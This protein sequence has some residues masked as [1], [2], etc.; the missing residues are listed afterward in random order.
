MNKFLQ[1]FTSPIRIIK[2][3]WKYEPFY[4]LLS[5]INMLFIAVLPLISVYFPKIIL[6][7]ITDGYKYSEIIITVLVYC[8]I[9]L[10]INLISNIISNKCNF[11]SEQFSRKIK[12]KI[13]VLS[14]Q[15]DLNEIESS[16]FKELVLLANNAASLTGTIGLVQ[17]IISNVITISGLM[18]IIVKLEWIF[19]LLIGITLTIKTVFVYLHFSYTKKMRFK[20]VSI[21]R[22]I[23][24]LTDITYYNNGTAKEIRLNNIQ[25]WIFEKVKI[26]RGKMVDLNIKDFRR[27]TIFDITNTVI[28]SIQTLIILWMLSARYINNDISIADF[29]MYFSAVSLLTSSLSGITEQ[30][31][32]YNQQIVN[33]N[34]FF[35][36][37]DL[38]S[39]NKVEKTVY[40]ESVN[41]KEVII[42]FEDVSFTYPGTKKEVL[43]NI[44]IE[45]E[46]NQKLVIVGYNGAGKTTFIKLLCKFYKPTKGKISINGTDI[47]D[48]PNDKYFK[49]IA[50]VFQDFANLSFSLSENI[51]MSEN[52]DEEKMMEILREIGLID[53]IDE[54]PYGIDT[55]ITRNFDSNGIELSG[56]QDQKLAIS[57]ALYKN[58]PILILDEPT[59]NLDAKSESDIYMKFFQISKHKTTIFISHRL[60][61]STVAD[62]IAVFA[63][64]SI[65]EYGSHDDLMQKN[66]IYAQMYKKQSEK[67]IDNV[68]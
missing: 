31:G 56:G 9:I 55:Y 54:L 15:K 51:S 10:F 47:W 13:G 33:M 63:E 21:N 57:R 65:K 53:K 20:Y 40:I 24:Y 66:G 39:E 68:F 35:K 28:L 46:N 29:T 23:D 49:L 59:A 42:K 2:I 1:K 25:N 12:Y 64:G 44:N 48:I 8:G 5:F 22:N 58:T 34:D 3:I 36:L 50:A 26:F 18:Y 37:E 62:K 67:Y 4:I 11:Y 27:N 30:I 45:I 32:S 19:I 41:D 60:A 16:S 38:Q 6:Q 14:M 52:G 17:G 7:Q 61:A 43:T